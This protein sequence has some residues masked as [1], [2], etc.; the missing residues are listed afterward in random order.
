ML[1]KC[2][3]AYSKMLCMY[4]LLNYDTH[5]M[6]LCVIIMINVPILRMRKLKWREIR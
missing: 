5:P 3:R 6:R 4:Y 2:Q 1:T